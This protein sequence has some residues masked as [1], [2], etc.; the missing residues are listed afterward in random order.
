VKFHGTPGG[1]VRPAPRLGQHTREVLVESGFDEVQI[2]G[3]LADG[4]AIDAAETD[5]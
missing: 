5:N 2:R 1:S 4:A 3:M